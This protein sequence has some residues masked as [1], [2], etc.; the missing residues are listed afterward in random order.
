MNLSVVEMTALVER[1]FLIKETIEGV[2]GEPH[3]VH[4]RGTLTKPSIEAYAELEKYLAPAKIVPLFRELNG[5]HSIFLVPERKSQKPA[6]WWVNIVFF[7]LTLFSVIYAGIAYSSP[8]GFPATWK[9]FLEE[10]LE[11][12]IPF[13]VSM[14][15]ILGA[16]EFGHYFAGRRHGVQVTLPYFIPMPF[17]AF[18]T[19]GAFINMREQPRNRRDLLDIAVSGPFAGLIVSIIVLIIGLHLSSLDTIP[20]VFPQGYGT[21][22]EGNSVLYL[23]LKWSVFGRILPE[24]ATFTLPPWM[25]WIQYFFTGH[26]APFGATDVIL[27]PVA[28]AGWA[29]LLVTSINLIP[30]GQLD[31]GHLFYVL[32]GEKTSRKTIPVIVGVLILMGFLWEGWWLW[33]VI[34]LFIGRAHAQPRDQITKVDGKRK[35][36]AVA[37]LVVFLLTFTPVPLLVYY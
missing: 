16:H 4:Y 6:R 30:V 14:I 7:V 31:G 19:M 11:G 10:L 32:F 2:S 17:S 8:D 29:G 34:L 22:M 35:I 21:Q 37:G 20:T 12:G 18:G 1:V 9:T 27:S 28:W 33:A 3:L 23:F 25:H 15:A 5:Q 26:P 24:P 13:A 36:V